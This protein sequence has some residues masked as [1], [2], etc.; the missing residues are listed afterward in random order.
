MVLPKINSAV[1]AKSNGEKDWK[2]LK[3][4][5]NGGKKTGQYKNYLNVLNTESNETDCVD[6]SKVTEWRNVEE[7]ILMSEELN[8]EDVLAAKFEEMDKW[9]DF[10]T[11]TE[12]LNQGQK[13]I[14]T[15]WICTKKGNLVKA[16]LV[17][18]GYEDDGN[19][20][21]TDSPTIVKANLRVL[22]TIATS[23][24]WRINFFIDVQSAF[25]QGR[26]INQGNIPSSSS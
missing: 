3:I 23:K 25:L 19:T 5:S 24:K 2:H 6:W 10:E 1:V 20:E 15:R 12:V 18:R 21:K 22:F 16:R 7:E 13:A 26:G 17:A 11:Y 8:K 9:V 14:S 4:I